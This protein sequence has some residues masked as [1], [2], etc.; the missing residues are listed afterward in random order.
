[1]LNMNLRGRVSP[2]RAQLVFPGG[3]A[4]LF[5]VHIVLVNGVLNIKRMLGKK[6]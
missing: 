5:H 4:L 3:P 6:I 1:M 2:S